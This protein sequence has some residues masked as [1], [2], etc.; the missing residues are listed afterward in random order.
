M[1]SK[2]SLAV[3]AAGRF[4]GVVVAACSHRNARVGRLVRNAEQANE[5]Q[6]CGAAKVIVCDL[7]DGRSVNAALAGSD[8]AFS[9]APAFL[10][11]EAETGRG[12]WMQWGVLA[13]QIVFSSVIHPVLR[14]ASDHLHVLNHHDS[15]GE[16]T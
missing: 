14:R 16:E 11:D 12:S 3:G 8:A 6:R 15:N 13:R 4:A 7:R 2:T 1:T 5:A 10:A 9:I